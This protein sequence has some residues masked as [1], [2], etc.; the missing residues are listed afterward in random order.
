[1]DTL[2]G[3]GRLLIALPLAL[4]PAALQA[5]YSDCRTCHYATTV[6]GSTPDYTDY[7]IDPGH[8]PVRVT[9]PNSLDYNQ[10][11]SSTA[12]LQFFDQNGNGAAD[13]DEIQIFSSSVLSTSTT[14]G[15][16]TKGKGTKG[17][18]KTTAPSS[19]SWVIDCASCH[20]EHGTSPPDPNHPPDYLRTAGGDRFL[21]LTCHRL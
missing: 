2:R 14:S 9:Y 4:A 21:C 6:D 17:G 5:D 1:M 20:T 10:P 15:T 13:P 19:D 3:L 18:P 8:H 16:T 12:G 7:F 11:A